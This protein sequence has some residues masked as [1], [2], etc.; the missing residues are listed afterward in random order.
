MESRKSKHK[1]IRDLI[2]KF[3][4][5]D[6]LNSW[7]VHKNRRGKVLTLRFVDLE[8][9]D[10]NCTNVSFDRRHTFERKSDKQIQRSRKIFNANKKQGTA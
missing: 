9:E 3:L 6:E 2:E 10:T 1:E 8:D 7:T 5:E 4:E